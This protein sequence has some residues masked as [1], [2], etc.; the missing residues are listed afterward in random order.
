MTLHNQAL[1]N[2]EENPTTGFEK[3]QFL[4]QQVTCP[5]GTDSLSHSLTHSLTHTHSH[6]HTHTHTPST[7]ETFANLLLLYIK[8]EYFDL[9]ADVLAENSHL[10]FKCLSP[11]LFDF[12]DAKITQ[13]TSPDEVSLCRFNVYYTLY[14]LPFVIE[15]MISIILPCL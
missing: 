10:T 5:P 12:I 1:M 3:L 14:I 8:H 11:Y 9:A 4:L 7:T 2:M 13:Q 6:T 15:K